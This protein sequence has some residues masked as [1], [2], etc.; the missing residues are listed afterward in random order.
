M[1][2]IMAEIARLQICLTLSTRFPKEPNKDGREGLGFGRKSMR[3][4]ATTTKANWESN[5]AK[6]MID[7]V[8]AWY[9]FVVTR[10][11]FKNKNNTLFIFI[12]IDKIKLK[13]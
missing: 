10:F 13:L 4:I 2:P 5:H 11:G 7:D 3:E 8:F 9:G 1:L 6:T 12:L